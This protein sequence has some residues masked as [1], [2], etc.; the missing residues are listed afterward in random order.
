MS[1][2]VYENAT[3]PQAEGYYRLAEENGRWAKI[4]PMEY[5]SDCTAVNLEGHLILPPFADAHIHLDYV[6]TAPLLKQTNLSGTLFEGIRRWSEAKASFTVTD[7]LER[8]RYAVKAQMLSGVQH[9]RT[10]VDVTDPKLTGLQALLAL[11]EEVKDS[12]TLQLVAFPQEGMLSYPRGAE[13]MEEALKL[14]ADAVGGIPHYE[15]TREIGVDSLRQIMRLAEKYGKQIDIHCD[16]TD[17]EQSR[18]LETLASLSKAAGMGA[19][20]TASHACAMGS[21]SPAYRTRLDKLLVSCGLHFAI[22]PAENLH[23]QGRGDWVA[24]RRGVAPVSHLLDMGLNVSFAQDSI[25]DPWYPL[26]SGNLM[27]VLDI[28]VHACQLAS[29]AYLP[30]ILD[31]VTGNPLRALYPDQPMGIAE[32]LP[33]SFVVLD[34]HNSQEAL[35]QHATVLRSVRNGKTLFTRHPAELLTATDYLKS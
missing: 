26:G 5:R 10:H 34:A 7:I 35:C 12:F 27:H 4:E 33:A 23:L 11:R 24:Q 28:G 16:E 3:L 19:M 14:G 9:A 2:T 22:C 29:P 6:Y 30:G 17:D 25:E 13:L 32:G 20:T 18:F 21:Y 15:E 1:H 31:L 8:A